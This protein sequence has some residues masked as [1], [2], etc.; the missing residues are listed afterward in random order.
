VV[1]AEYREVPPRVRELALLDVLDP[2]AED[3]E[4]NAILLFARHGAGVAA[5]ASRLVD[6]EA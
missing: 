3:A 2:G 1:T 5:D 4:R 6:H